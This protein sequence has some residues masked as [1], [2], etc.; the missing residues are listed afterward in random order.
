M[1][2]YYKEMLKKGLH[3]QDFVVEE[4]YKIGLPIISYSSKEFQNM[5]GE[6]KAG[7]EI[8]LDQNF[9]KTG[10][11]YIEYAEKSK[12]ENNNYIDSGVLR[13]DNTWL[14]LI[15]DYET[16]YIF[17]KKQLLIL[18][19]TS[20]VRHVQTPTSKGYLLSL[21]LVEKYCIKVIEVSK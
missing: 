6:N 4:L 17:S 13:N 16:I 14:Y 11:I 1:N 5:I 20:K 19:D 15:G 12:A 21:N 18:K 9:R 3:F 8:K 10:N 2:E 7:I